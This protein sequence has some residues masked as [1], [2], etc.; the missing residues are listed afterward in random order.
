M[1]LK[2]LSEM[3]TCTSAIAAPPGAI[4]YKQRKKKNVLRDDVGKDFG[5]DIADEDGHHKACNQVWQTDEHAQKTQMKTAG[6]L[7]PAHS[8]AGQGFNPKDRYNSYILKAK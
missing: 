2:E 1:K 6:V 8:Y 3:S 7:Q 4:G 5:A